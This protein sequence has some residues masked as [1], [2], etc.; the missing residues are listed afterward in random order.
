MV[1][2]ERPQEGNKSQQSIPEMVRGNQPHFGSQLTFICH[3][4]DALRSHA[5]L[6][7][8]LSRMN[9]ASTT[10]SRL[11][12]DC[13]KHEVVTQILRKCISATEWH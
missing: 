5:E 9:T 2:Y 7:M 10:P 11:G 4:G 8:S 3:L 12:F 6:E 13:V 1:W